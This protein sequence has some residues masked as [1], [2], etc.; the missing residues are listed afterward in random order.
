MRNRS[1]IEKLNSDP[2]APTTWRSIHEVKRPA[3]IPA[4]KKGIKRTSSCFQ[5]NFPR[6]HQKTTSSAAG[7]VAITVFAN[8]PSTKSTNAPIYAAL[9]LVRSNR[10]QARADRSEE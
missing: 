10:K 2:W 8:K 3:V 9:L 7:M 4:A 1:R 5:D 6:F